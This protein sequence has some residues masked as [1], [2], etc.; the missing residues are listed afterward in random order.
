MFHRILGGQ[1]ARLAL[2]RAVY[3]VRSSIDL[4]SFTR[5]HCSTFTGQKHLSIGRSAF[6]RRCSCCSSSFSS[7]SLSSVATQNASLV[8]TSDS[9]CSSSGLHYLTRSWSYRSSWSVD[10][11]RRCSFNIGMIRQAG[12]CSRFG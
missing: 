3:Q 5:E 10:L 9:I 8:H 2:A 4:S 12:R 11:F 1:K 6:C 7:L